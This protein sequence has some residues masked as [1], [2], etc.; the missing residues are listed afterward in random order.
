MWHYS[1]AQ[2]YRTA[3]P[4]SAAIAQSAYDLLLGMRGVTATLLFL[5]LTNADKPV[6]EVTGFVENVTTTTV[7]LGLAA[8]LG[9]L[10]RRTRFGVEVMAGPGIL[11][12]QSVPHSAPEPGASRVHLQLPAKIESVQRRKFS[13]I[14]LNTGVAFSYATCGLD[15]A[16]N[17]QGGLG[18][19]ADFSAGGLRFTTSTP[20]HYG[21]VLLV[22]FN[23]PD[24]ATYRSI[25]GRVTRV[26][27]E[28][29]L[30]TVGLQFL[31]MDDAQADHMVQTVFRLQI[32]G[33]AKP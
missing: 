26:H 11:R 15:P 2:R 33:L 29:G 28:G 20:L 9:A 10:G 16:E 5:D 6:R 21:Q 3:L 17:Q 24:G 1:Q 12:F 23:T 31:E 25:A 4:P 7:T 22:S 32:K 19:T 8:P 30:Y 14:A 27:S 18:Q 13:R